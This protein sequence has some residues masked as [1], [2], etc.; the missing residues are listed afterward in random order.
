MTIEK[1]NEIKELSKTINALKRRLAVTKAKSISTTSSLSGVPRAPG[2]SDKV[3]NSVADIDEIKRKI[4]NARRRR[5]R[6]KVYI[7]CIDDDYMREIMISKF[8]DGDT[9]EGIA[10]EIG[11]GNTKDSVRKSCERFLEREN[12]KKH[13]VRAR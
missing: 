13:E 2:I 5:K 3:G 6:L 4:H 10:A 9:W 11:N 12:M 8:I 7:Y 1:L